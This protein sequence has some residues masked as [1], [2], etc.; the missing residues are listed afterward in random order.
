M[1]GLDTNVLIRAFIVDE[2]EQTRMAKQLVAQECSEADPG[3][4]ASIVLAEAIWVLESV[5]GYRRNAI[6]ATVDNLLAVGD[7][8]FEHEADL[9]KALSEFS[10]HRAD[11]ADALLAEINRSAGCSST[12]TFDRKA[13]KLDGFMLVR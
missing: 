4:V 7:I 5:Y 2:G 11:F 13:A 9:R 10:V 6:A 1:I 3:Y 12:A 8:R